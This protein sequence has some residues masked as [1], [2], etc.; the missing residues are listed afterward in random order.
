MDLKPVGI[1]LGVLFTV[2]AASF[3]TGFYVLQSS[4]NNNLAY[5]AVYYDDM[6]AALHAQNASQDAVLVAA[7]QAVNFCFMLTS[8]KRT[9]DY[10][11]YWNL[12]DNISQSSNL[13]G[14][15]MWPEFQGFQEAIEPAKA[16]YRGL[17]PSMSFVFSKSYKRTRCMMSGEEY[18]CP[19]EPS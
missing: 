5:M 10:A 16:G 2:G 17:Y 6:T 15:E 18:P 8:E 11:R 13:A 12:C 7:S 14:A 3:A 1:L 9:L 19:W 4:F